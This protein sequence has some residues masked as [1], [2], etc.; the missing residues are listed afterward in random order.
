MYTVT[1]VVL[2]TSKWSILT[3]LP[4]YAQLLGKIPP[5]DFIQSDALFQEKPDPVWSCSQN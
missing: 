4:E 2:K 1:L 5:Y 3:E